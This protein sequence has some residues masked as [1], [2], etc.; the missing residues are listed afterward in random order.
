[1]YD[2]LLLNGKVMLYLHVHVH[3]RTCVYSMVWYKNYSIYIKIKSHISFELLPSIKDELDFLLLLQ[4]KET[5]GR[6][7]YNYSKYSTSATFVCFLIILC[8]R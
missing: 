7:Q 4:F 1:M 6:G 3:V 5:C 8:G 2:G